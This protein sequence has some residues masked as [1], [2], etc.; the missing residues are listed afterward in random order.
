MLTKLKWNA[1]ATQP[2]L[3]DQ[4]ARQ[5]QRQCAGQ[6]EHKT[7]RSVGNQIWIPG[8]S[9]CSTLILNQEWALQ[10]K[11]GLTRLKWDTDG[12]WPSFMEQL[13]QQLQKQYMGQIEHEFLI[14]VDIQILGPT[15]ARF[16]LLAIS[17]I[18]NTLRS[19]V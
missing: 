10:E 14:R 15:V 9:R 17:Q 12:R 3:K 16:D 18:K 7:C 8:R 11:M 5:L 2:A 1:A 19:P 6:V 4:I 13:K